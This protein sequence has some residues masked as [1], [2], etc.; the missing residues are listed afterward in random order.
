MNIIAKLLGSG[1]ILCSCTAIG[2]SYAGTIRRSRETAQLLYRYWSDFLQQMTLSA[3]PP[4]KIAATLGHRTAYTGFSFAQEL[5][6][7]RQS[8]AFS[9]ILRSVIQSSAELTDSM[10]K[11]LQPLTE[12]LGRTPMQT[13]EQV[14]HSVLAAVRQEEK[15]WAE[16]ETRQGTLSRRLGILGGIVLV[17]LLI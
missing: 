5:G 7:R 9:D 12:A 1:L 11:T 3:E 6:G 8:G 16:R 2:F 10:K 13:E 15:Y 17:V 14:L 4:G